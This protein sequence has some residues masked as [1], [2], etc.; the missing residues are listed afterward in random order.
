MNTWVYYGWES[1]IIKAVGSPR[2]ITN[3]FGINISSTAECGSGIADDNLIIKRECEGLG[4]KVNGPAFLALI[5]VYVCP[6][7]WLPMQYL[8]SAPSTGRC[9]LP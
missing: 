3:H 5:P 9:P 7:V 8:L 2:K 4:L 6:P 1:N